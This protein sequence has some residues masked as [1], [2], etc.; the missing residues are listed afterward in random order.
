[1][2]TFIIILLFS[3]LII[4]IKLLGKRPPGLSLFITG[5]ENMEKRIMSK[6]AEFLTAQETYNAAISSGIEALLTSVQG[7][8]GDIE[9]LNTQINELKVN[10]VSEEDEAKID[11]LQTAGTE[12]ATKLETVVTALSVLDA[13]TPP[14]TTEVTPDPTPENTVPD[15][16]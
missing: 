6:L 5:L 9:S 15:S 7:I 12:L 16:E 13:Q 8:A 4:V 1:M 3:I 2:N 10:S 11:A 14:A